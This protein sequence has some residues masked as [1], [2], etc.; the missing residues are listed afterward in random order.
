MGS[1]EAI[2]CGVPILGIPLFADQALN[3]AELKKRGVVKIIK[4]NDFNEVTIF[5]AINNML[6]D[7]R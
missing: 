6:N 4:Y 2:N 3:L 5:N 7:T 1:Q